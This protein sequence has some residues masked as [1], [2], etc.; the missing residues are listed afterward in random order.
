MK[1]TCLLEPHSVHLWQ[2]VVPELFVHINDFSSILNAAEIQRAERFHFALHR[3]RYIIT[4]AMLRHILSCYTGIPAMDITF[5]TGKHGKPYLADNVNLQFN[6]SHSHDRVVY[7]FTAH[8]EIGIDIEKIE[9][10]FNE[11]VAQ[12]F[13]SASEYAA[14]THLPEQEKITA[15]YHLWAGKEA[16]IKAVGEGLYLPLASFSIDLPKKKQIVYL[17]RQQEKYYLEYFIADSGYQ[18]AF[19]T[20]QVV[21][22]VQR[23]Q[24]TVNGPAILES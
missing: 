23:W 18:S 4:R 19:A 14:L 1:Q 17:D 15:F 2:A 20:T 16:I 5:N 7:A 22:T 11:K 6:L 3:E 13:F 12:R 8:A 10:R 9:T 24:W 21:E